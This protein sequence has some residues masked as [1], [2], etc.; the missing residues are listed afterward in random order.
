MLRVLLL[1]L[2]YGSC[3]LATPSR[4]AA[5]KPY[6]SREGVF[7]HLPVRIVG[8]SIAHGAFTVPCHT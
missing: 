8:I 5:G 6:E 1:C 2:R 7:A 3:A 4:S